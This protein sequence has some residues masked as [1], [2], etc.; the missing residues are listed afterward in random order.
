MK[1]KTFSIL[2]TFMTLVP[3]LSAKEPERSGA[4]TVISYNIRNGE[5][6]DG[7]NS[8]EYRFPASAM[9]IDDQAPDI[10][11]L[12]EAYDYQVK[13]LSEYTD[14]YKSIGV[15][16]ENGKK[17]GKEGGEHMEIFYKTKNISLLKWGTFWLAET[18][19]KP[20][21]GWDAACKRTAT[22]AL[23]KDK[24]TGKKFFYVNTH[25]DHVGREAQ[26][27]GLAL[28]LERIAS[29]NP[30]GVPMVLT[31]D[32]NVTP[33]DKI[34]TGLNSKM[35]SARDYAVKSDRGGTF[36]DW[37]REKTVK[38]I[39]YIYFSGF[40]SCPV[41]EVIRKSY[42]ERNFISDHFPVKAVLV[43]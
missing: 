21:L 7:T 42:M 31:G 11:G 15:G 41:F 28:I 40:S 1:K 36:N 39:D 3:F 20:V 33:D 2:L 22:W 8:W 38:A 10:F 43:F 34:L 13:Y 12:Q 5:S 16:R 23:M 24:R 18:P 27:K 14:G 19:D 35:K 4:L 37:G 25:L 6:E 29:M 9:M 32:F 30:D 26:E 17:K